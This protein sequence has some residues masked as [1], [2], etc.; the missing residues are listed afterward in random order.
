[1]RY[2]ALIIDQDGPPDAPVA[3][4]IRELEAAGLPVR[5]C[6]AAPSAA[7]VAGLRR[8]VVVDPPCADL[9]YL[10][11]VKWSVDFF[12]FVNEGDGEINTTA[13]VRVAGRPVFFDAWRGQFSPATA[14]RSDTEGLAIPLR[15]RRHDSLILCVEPGEPATLA[16]APLSTHGPA[17]RTPVGGPW[18]TLTPDGKKVGDGPGDWTQAP[19]TAAWAGMLRYETDFEL[20]RQAGHTY[21]LDLGVVHDWAVVRVN[22]KDAGPRFWAPF[23]WDVTDLVRDGRNE[24]VVEVTNSL[25]NRYEPSKRRPSGLLGPVEVRVLSSNAPPGQP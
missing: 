19:A 1:M 17:K 22:G 21:E 7:M 6:R 20:R 3:D 15:L 2:A 9:R 16:A 18:R 8:D 10:H 12:L 24:L 13:R 23:A 11:V 25:A 14:V 4:R 5:Y